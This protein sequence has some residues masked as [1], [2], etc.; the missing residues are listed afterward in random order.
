MTRLLLLAVFVGALDQ[1]VVAA[2]LPAIVRDLSLPFDRL[3]EAAWAVTL[4]LAAY[5]AVVPF[6][7]RLIDAGA[8]T[9]VLVGGLFV[10]GIGSFLCGRSDTLEQLVA[11][12]V[13]QALGAGVLLPVALAGASRGE[14]HRRLVRVGVVAAVAE[15]GAVC[16][17]IYGAVVLAAFDWRWAFW[18]NLPV[19]AAVAAVSAS[20][21]RLR[22]P[23]LP[24]SALVGSLAL[25]LALG[26][27]VAGLSREVARTA[28]WL[29]PACAV[30]AAALLLL[31]VGI[32]RRLRPP[33]ALA[34][35]GRVP[36]FWGI[37]G[38]HLAL[39]VALVTPLVLIPVW[40]ST[41]LALDPPGAAQVLLWLTLAIPPTALLGAG[42]ASRLGRRATAGL[43]FSLVAAGLFSMGGWSAT[44]QVSEMVPAL[45]IAG[46]GFGLVIAPLTDLVFGFA[47]LEAVGS[48]VGLATA[49]RVVGMAIGLAALTRWGIDQLTS[50]LA[51]LPSP[52]FTGGLAAL[53]G[54]A[55]YQRAVSAIGADIFGSLFRAAAICA[56]LAAIGLLAVQAPV[57]ARQS[58]KSVVLDD[59]GSR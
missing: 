26:V 31:V 34:S 57:Q 27:A 6:A 19:V 30:A 46:L 44:I 16:G 48:A 39:G 10:F 52:S 21:D 38:I 12:R 59:G 49:A 20:T 25:G 41:L 37:L 50:R 11:G 22:L 32:E 7:G 35:L 36:G 15:A 55:D 42:A 17:P 24:W 56:V 58:R 29:P 45:V 13:V 28:A 54:L 18:I 5:A 3:D 33:S 53:A 1:T 14:A 4:Y 23:R 9:V 40:A 51:E 43:G 47:D 8:R 2:L